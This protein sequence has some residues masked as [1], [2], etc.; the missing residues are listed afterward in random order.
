[1]IKEGLLTKNGPID[2]VH[3]FFPNSPWCKDMKSVEKMACSLDSDPSINFWSLTW[4]LMGIFTSWRFKK[5]T[6]RLFFFKLCR[7]NV[8]TALNIMAPKNLGVACHQ[9]FTYPSITSMEVNCVCVNYESRDKFN[10]V[11][12]LQHYGKIHCKP[13]FFIN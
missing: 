11:R 10:T 12:M 9:N 1:M 8:V 6:A 5:K 3:N 4:A 2:F 13:F 7:N